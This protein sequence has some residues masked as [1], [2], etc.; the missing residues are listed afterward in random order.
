[1]SEPELI[2]A[3]KLWDKITEKMNK[4]EYVMPDALDHNANG[5]PYTSGDF[6]PLQCRIDGQKAE[7]TV[8]SASGHKAHI[9]LAEKKLEY[10]DTDEL[11]NEVVKDL[12]ESVGLKC[13][14]DSDG[15]KCQGLTKGN[16]QAAFKVL[17][18]PTSMDF[19]LDH[20]TKAQVSPE[21]ECRQRCEDEQPAIPDELDTT[22]VRGCLDDWVDECT[23]DC[24]DNY[25]YSDVDSTDC[26]AEEKRFF[27]EGP[28]KEELSKWEAVVHPPSEK[29]ITE[30]VI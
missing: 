12:L 5:R 15:V 26:Q 11:P 17:A 4:G 21:D 13:R 18:M 16:V 25:D 6:Q 27:E 9:D 30:W 14:K 1:M 8:G 23:S 29:K 10:Y 7:L 24:V 2:R 19:R 28:K 3:C 20:C 22:C